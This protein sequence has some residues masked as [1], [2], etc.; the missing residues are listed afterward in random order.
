MSEFCNIPI[1]GPISHTSIKYEN[2]RARIDYITVYSMNS[3][4]N[5]S[6]D[7]DVNGTRGRLIGRFECEVRKLCLRIIVK[8]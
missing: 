1:A 8:H 7:N 3:I 6:G 2:V 4:Q 5:K